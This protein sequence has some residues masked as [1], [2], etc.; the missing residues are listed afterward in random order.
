MAAMDEHDSIHS[1]IVVSMDKELPLIP[2]IGESSGLR[3]RIRKICI[4][5]WIWEL[6]SLVL[7][8]SCIGA[9]IIILL[10]HD[11]KQLPGWN[12]GIT[13]NGLISV[14][15]GIAKASM[16]LPVAESISQLKWHW[17]WKG[18]ARPVVDF[19]YFDTASRGPWG[20]LILLCRPKQWGLATIGAAVTV[21][22]LLM[23]PSLQFVPAYPMNPVISA[24]AFTPRSV[25]Y[26]DI[27]VSQT[28]DTSKG[29]NGSA[30]TTA[31]KRK[32]P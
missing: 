1:A 16:I 30:Y 11:G 27:F 28:S 4:H 18:Q 6:L 29:T 3:Q 13:I 20:C 12:Y 25:Y 14:L 2:E 24:R 10:D 22:A 23:E 31:T 8:M 17:Y 19:E 32:F 9:I 15:A 7:C 5:L 21:L 26:N